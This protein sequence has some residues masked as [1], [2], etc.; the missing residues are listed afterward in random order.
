MVTLAV[1]SPEAAYNNRCFRNSLFFRDVVASPDRLS[2]KP[3]PNQTAGKSIFAVTC[4]K[5]YGDKPWFGR[6]LRGGWPDIRGPV[7]LG[8]PTKNRFGELVVVYLD[9]NRYPKCRVL[10]TGGR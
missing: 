7:T 10:E 3:D 2:S 1:R 4:E 9:D 6:Q 5:S 8:E